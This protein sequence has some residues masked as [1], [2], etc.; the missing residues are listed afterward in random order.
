MFS[1]QVIELAPKNNEALLKLGWKGWKPEVGEQ[2]LCANNDIFVVLEYS[3][4]TGSVATYVGHII[5]PGSGQDPFMIMSVDRIIPIFHWERLRK[6]LKELGYDVYLSI[7]YNGGEITV[8][9]IDEY[10]HTTELFS[11]FYK[12]EKIQER[13]MQAVIKLGEEINDKK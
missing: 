11:L 9:G 4:I 1:K 2:F 7:G 3:K 10:E 6:I 12:G 5:P 8:N 13:V